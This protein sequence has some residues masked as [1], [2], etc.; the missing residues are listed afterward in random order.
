MKP[1]LVCSKDP[2]MGGAPHP[3]FLDISWPG[4]E[5][6]GPALL[7]RPLQNCPPELLQARGYLPI[8][9]LP[10]PNCPPGLC[11]CQAPTATPAAIANC[12]PISIPSA[13]S[14]PTVLP[15]YHSQLAAPCSISFAFH[16]PAMGP[17]LS[18]PEFPAFATILERAKPHLLCSWAGR[19]CTEAQDQENRS[20]PGLSRPR[21]RDR[22]NKAGKEENRRK[23]QSRS[24]SI[25]QTPEL[26]QHRGRK[27][28]Q[29]PVRNKY[30]P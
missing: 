24:R 21:G 26:D 25:S 4:L 20:G 6:S 12:R 3:G 22:K 16:L 7:S 9:R 17:G 15:K 1:A 18:V 10:H 2:A 30:V 5:P 23:K 14:P 13:P 27:Q 28:P 8:A 11:P 19:R 29:C